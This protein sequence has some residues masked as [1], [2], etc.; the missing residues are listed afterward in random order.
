MLIF[1]HIPKTAGTSF[2]GLL[3]QVYKPSETI[4]IDSDNWHRAGM[5]NQV[6][7]S[8]LPG[9]VATKPSSNIKCIIGHFDANR[10]IN[11]YPDATFVTWVRDP[12]QRLI[13]QHNYYMRLGTSHYGTINTEK[14]K[15]DIIDL[16]TYC[17]HK[18]NINSMRQQINIPLNGFKFIGIAEKYEQEIIR[19]KK[20]TGIEL[21]FTTEFLNINPEKKNVNESYFIPDNLK[22]ELINLHSEDYWPWPP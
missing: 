21:R 4:V 8:G 7:R 17:T 5:F 11:D 13:S 10:F 3:K 22:Q 19:F 20:I 12:I 2:K 14:R 18:R 9:S 16:K 6:D 1:V 15:Y